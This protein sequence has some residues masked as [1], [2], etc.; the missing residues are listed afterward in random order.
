MSRDNE[1]IKAKLF[2][3]SSVQRYSLGLPLDRG[4]QSWSHFTTFDPHEGI[5]GGKEKTFI[6]CH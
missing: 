1:E 2:M 5:F 3:F 4:Y 6:D